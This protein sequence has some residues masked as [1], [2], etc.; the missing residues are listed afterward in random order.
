MMESLESEN[1]ANFE[2]SVCT[3]LLILKIDRVEVAAA[4]LQSCEI[5]Y[6]LAQNNGGLS[7]PL[8]S[9]SKESQ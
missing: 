7:S 1:E 4:S 9:D 8:H 3:N 6:K 5:T 2:V